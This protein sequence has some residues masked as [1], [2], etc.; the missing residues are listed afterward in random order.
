[1]T[2]DHGLPMEEGSRGLEVARAN[3]EVYKSLGSHATT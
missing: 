2:D 1:M 3:P